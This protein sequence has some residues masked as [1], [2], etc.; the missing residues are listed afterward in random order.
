[1]N[2][3]PFDLASTVSSFAVFNPSPNVRS[4]EE[5]GGLLVEVPPPPKDF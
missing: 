1:L 5:S 3:L 4:N 2:A